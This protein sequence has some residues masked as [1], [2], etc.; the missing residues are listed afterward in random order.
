MKKRLLL[1][2]F[3]CCLTLC[4]AACGGSEEDPADPTFCGA[5]TAD[6]ADEQKL[7]SVDTSNAFYYADQKNDRYILG[8]VQDQGEGRY[9]ITCQDPDNAAILP[10]Q[11]IAYDGDGFS[12][13]IEDQ[14]Y[15]FQKTDDV[16]LIVGDTSLY[17]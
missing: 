6:M 4:L 14:L 5:Y 15:I 7:F 13:T 8:Q 3:C 1:L 11:E 10:N 12:L 2:L 17:S 16:P 9:V